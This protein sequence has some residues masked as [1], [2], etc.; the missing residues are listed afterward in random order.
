MQNTKAA[1]IVS[2]S[3]LIV[4]PVFFL[5]VSLF[6]GQWKYLLFS[7]PPSIASGLTGLM[8]TLRQIKIERK[9]A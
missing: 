3:A 8:L 2:L 4:I 1:L 5:I 9:S 7:I 6:T